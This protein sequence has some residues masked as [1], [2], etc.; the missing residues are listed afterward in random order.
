MPSKNEPE[1]MKI[2]VF[3]FLIAIAKHKK[4]IFWFTIIG[5]VFA[6]LFSIGSLLLQKFWGPE[7]SYYPNIYK[8]TAT[9]IFNESENKTI[10]D[11]SALVGVKNQS[12]K[13]NLV[14]NFLLSRNT[15]NS[16]IDDLNLI[17][18]FKIKPSARY[19]RQQCQE[20]LKKCF[21]IK[22]E[23]DK[24]I[25]SINFIHYDPRFAEK[26]LLHSLKLLEDQYRNLTVTKAKES[27]GLLDEQI[28]DTE[29]SLNEKIKELLKWQRV[30]DVLDPV[31]QANLKSDSIARIEM[32]IQER[33]FIRQ[34]LANNLGWKD[35]QVRQIS[36]EIKQL[37]NQ[38]DI[39]VDGSNASS[40]FNLPLTKLLDLSVDYTKLSKEIDL[41]EKLYVQL[42][43][44]Q[45]T[46][47]MDKDYTTNS[48]QIIDKPNFYA[49]LGEDELPQEEPMKYKPSRGRFCIVVT[50]IFFFL[51]L[52]ISITKEFLNI[53]ENTQDGSAQLYQ[54]KKN[55][56][57]KKKY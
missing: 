47:V 42:R 13:I 30:N 32:E 6:L 52:A 9:I 49:S 55:L 20:K 14:E 54:L 25:V 15:L 44:Q 22:T 37:Q 43:V 40:R 38:V 16:L 10:S 34:Q 41:L 3:D 29:T 11:L 5:A 36:N 45:Y 17:E 26:I 4:F 35:P 50:F 57:L 8:S 51:G 53:F 46:T 56:S 28:K 23:N 27:Y 7:H 12:N 19:P 39:L 24:N 33:T 2:S 21:K 48:F 31:K 18:F 1:K